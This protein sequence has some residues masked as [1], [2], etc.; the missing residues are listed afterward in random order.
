MNG[1]IGDFWEQPKNPDEDWIQCDI[2]LK[3]RHLTKTNSSLKES[4]TFTCSLLDLRPSERQKE[5][6]EQKD[7]PDACKV[8]QVANCMCSKVVFLATEGK[9]RKIP[10]SLTAYSAKIF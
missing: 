10:V 2:C 1:R 7:L 8:P 4:D 6:T 9:K 5:K 3:W